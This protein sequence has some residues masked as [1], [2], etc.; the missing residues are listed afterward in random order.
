M[1]TLENLPATAE[2]AFM[3]IGST[4]TPT[5]DDFKLM[6]YLEASGQG[7]YGALAEA[8]PTDEIRE[9]LNSNGREEMAHATRLQRV[10][11]K[12]TGEDFAIPEPADNPYY[13][14]PANVELTREMLETIA[15]GEFGGDA[16]Y[17]AWADSLDD[18]ECAKWLRQN[19][20]EETRHGERAMKVADLLDAA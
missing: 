8:A 20:K 12:M 5:V 4:A 7:Y 17:G 14:P 18:E 15:Q 2:E 9:L 13:D 19:G 6:I 10:I 11:K 1:A 16:L 3:K